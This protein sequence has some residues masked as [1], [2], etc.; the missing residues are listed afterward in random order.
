MISNSPNSIKVPENKYAHFKKN[1]GQYEYILYRLLD[2]N[3]EIN[4]I[5]KFYSYDKQEKILKTRK[6]Y[7]MNIADIYTENF[8]EL[9][10]E[11]IERSAILLHSCIILE[12]F[13]RK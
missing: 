9:P 1:V 12:L 4:F 7:G 10:V 6:I 5:P 13:I 2:N 11:I 8:N 3:S